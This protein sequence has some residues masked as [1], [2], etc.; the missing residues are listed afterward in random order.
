MADRLANL[1]DL[2]AWV[3]RQGGFTEKAALQSEKYLSEYEEF[4][5]LFTPKLLRL[6]EGDSHPFAFQ[7]SGLHSL[8]GALRALYLIHLHAPES[9]QARSREVLDPF[10]EMVDVMKY[11]WRYREPRSTRYRTQLIKFE[12]KW[13][14]EPR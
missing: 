14:E 1:F 7:I 11:K 3:E 2:I 12:S 9:F 5:P 6:A 10:G 4:V 8:M 13:K